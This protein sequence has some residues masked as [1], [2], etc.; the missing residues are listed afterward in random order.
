MA[1]IAVDDLVGAPSSE[2]RDPLVN[3]VGDLAEERLNGDGHGY[4]LQ[5]QK[6][7]DAPLCPPSGGRGP[8]GIE[9]ST[10]SSGCSLQKRAPRGCPEE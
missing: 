3:W 6:R 5:E 1:G 10:K 9:V 8:S 2:V 4:H 7:K